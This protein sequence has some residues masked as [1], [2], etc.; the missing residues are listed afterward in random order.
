MVPSSASRSVRICAPD[1]PTVL[2]FGRCVPHCRRLVTCSRCSRRGTL[3]GTA[4]LRRRTT[5]RL[6]AIE[7]LK[8]CLVDTQCHRRK[9]GPGRGGGSLHG[10]LASVRKCHGRVAVQRDRRTCGGVLVCPICL[11]CRFASG[12]TDQR[13]R[14]EQPASVLPTPC[15]CFITHHMKRKTRSGNCVFL[16]RTCRA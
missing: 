1:R 12:H 14:P 2:W 16:T 10:W 8:N 15:G 6:E 3:Y 9:N 13:A 4:S 5:R 7:C 11:S